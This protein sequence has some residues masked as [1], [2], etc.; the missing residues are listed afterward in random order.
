MWET[1]AGNP[2]CPEGWQLGPGL[3]ISE[4]RT[5]V[6]QAGRGARGELLLSSWP[7]VPVHGRST[8]QQLPGLLCQPRSLLSL[9]QHSRF[10][11]RRRIQLAQSP[12][13]AP[14]LLFAEC[15]ERCG[16]DKPSQPPPL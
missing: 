10:I 4:G 13:Q 16:R 8:A 1:A 6:T 9:P 12:R 5:R 7:L 2:A 14:V 11:S 15:G 3:N